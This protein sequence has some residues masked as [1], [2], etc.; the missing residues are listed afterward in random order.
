M[1]TYKRNT[2][3]ERKGKVTYNASIV[4]GIVALAVADVVGVALKK[5]GK[6]DKLEL[7]KIDFNGED[8]AVE[9]TVDILYG[10]SVTD[11]AYDIQQ[12]VMRNVESMS[13]YK[14]KNVSVN[15]DGV[16]FEEDN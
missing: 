12:S 16:F 15:F 9:V 6:K 8:I 7:I 4:K 14:V 11:V 2:N 3:N 1:A 13:K 10:Y 5:G